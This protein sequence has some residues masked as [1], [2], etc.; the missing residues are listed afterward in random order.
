MKIKVIIGLEIDE[1]ACK[2]MNVE[3]EEVARHISV[4]DD[5]V[6]DGCTVTTRLEGFHPVSD[7]FISLDQSPELIMVCADVELGDVLDQELEDDDTSEGGIDFPGE[8]VRDFIASLG[9]DAS[10]ILTVDDLNDALVDCGIL[11]VQIPVY[12]MGGEPV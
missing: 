4:E 11:P 2:E 1:D 3:P 8:T 7:F 10:G 12:Q 9:D 6:L 5:T